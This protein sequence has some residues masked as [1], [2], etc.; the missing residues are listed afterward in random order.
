M[1][2]P[3]TQIPGSTHPPLALSSKLCLRRRATPMVAAGQDTPCAPNL[4][5]DSS[6]SPHHLAGV[7][8]LDFKH[9]QVHLS[10]VI[11]ASFPRGACMLS[12]SWMDLLAVGVHFC[13]RH[14]PPC[15]VRCFQVCLRVLGS[16]SWKDPVLRRRPVVIFGT[17]SSS[18]VLQ[19]DGF[20]PCTQCLT[21]ARAQVL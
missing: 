19:S 18:I 1:N 17:S 7:T 8:T 20:P 3:A 2:P 16:S 12:G 5:I 14:Q 11:F 13:L 10:A 21:N 15:C 4:S 9:I 6:A